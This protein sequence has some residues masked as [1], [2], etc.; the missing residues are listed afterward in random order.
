MNVPDKLIQTTPINDLLTADLSV[1]TPAE[2]QYLLK[3]VTSIADSK[4]HQAGMEY[5]ITDVELVRR[6]NDKLHHLDLCAQIAYN[7]RVNFTDTFKQV[8]MWDAIIYFDLFKKSIAI[9]ENT[10]HSKTADYAG[11]YVKDPL[12]GKHSWIASFDVNSLYPSIMREWNISSDRHLSI[13]WL[14]NRAAELRKLNASVV[15]PATMDPIDWLY[16]AKLED[17]PYINWALQSLLEIAAST[18]VDNMLSD[19]E[20]D[21]PYPCL[22]VLSVCVSPNKQVFRSDQMGFL[23]EILASMYER[24]TVAKDRMIESQ[25]LMEHIDAELR[26]RGKQNAK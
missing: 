14:H 21:N 24:R 18:S 26:A 15:K 8:R 12:V 16:G 10:S 6:L 3:Q 5:N 7:A 13:E 20:N 9:P 22:R 19:I 4:C 17:I 2:R 1:Y 23:P 25:K 11:A